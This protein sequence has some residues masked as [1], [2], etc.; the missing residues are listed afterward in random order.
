MGTLGE[1]WGRVWPANGC[2]TT[3]GMVPGSAGQY[4]V[5]KLVVP[6]ATECL[7]TDISSQEACHVED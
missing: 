3:P 1:R 5:P 6:T 7:E 4:L 2:T